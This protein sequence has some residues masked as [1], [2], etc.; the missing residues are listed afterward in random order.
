MQEVY[1][2][3]N[4]TFL[5]SSLP[6]FLL[7]LESRS[8]NRTIEQDRPTTLCGHKWA[9][10]N[11]PKVPGFMERKKLYENPSQNR[12][13]FRIVTVSPRIAGLRPKGYLQPPSC[14]APPCAWRLSSRKVT[15]NWHV[16][17]LSPK[18]D[19]RHL[20]PSLRQYV[21]DSWELRKFFI[22]VL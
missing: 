3:I 10:C 7:I 1:D 15:A 17:L 12:T 16:R 13:S 14:L 11:V 8:H 19:R 22:G 21:L 18:T 20:S 6:I 9:W 2:L 5:Y 4:K